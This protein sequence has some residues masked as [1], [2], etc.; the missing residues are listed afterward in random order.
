MTISD[1]L[2]ILLVIT[3]LFFACEREKKKEVIPYKGPVEEINDIKLL[4]SEGG[5]LRVEMRS[6]KQLRYQA[7]DRLYPDTINVN[8]FDP[9]G[10]TIITTLRADSGRYDN[11]QSVYIVKGNVRIVKIQEQ[12]TLYTEELNWNP[13]TKKVYTEKHI[14]SINRLN[15]NVNEGEG[16]TT[17]QDFSYIVIKRPTASYFLQRNADGS[18]TF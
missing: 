12:E 4:Y 7:G 10:R 18:F 1:R 14:K 17:P 13:N 11:K 15:G 8:F 5:L 9:T 3:S 16:M 6:P 2:N